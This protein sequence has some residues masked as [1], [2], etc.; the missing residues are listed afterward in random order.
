MDKPAGR[1]VLTVLLGLVATGCARQRMTTRQRYEKGL[2]ICLP[3]AGGFNF[4]AK[5]TRKGLEKGG[6]EGAV[7][8]YHWSSMNVAKDHLNLERN[9][10]K[11]AE[12]ARRIEAYQTEYPNRPVHLI[13]QSAGSG[14]AAWAVG[15][16]SPGHRVTGLVFVASSL[17][18]RYDLSAV[19]RKVDGALHNF[20]NPLDVVLGVGTPVAGAVDGS[21]EPAGGQVGFELPPAADDETKRLYAERLVQHAWKPGDIVQGNAGD[22]LGATRAGFVRYRIAPIIRLSYRLEEPR[23]DGGAPDPGR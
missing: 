20:Y 1:L 2:V 17:G 15:D 5:S 4:M 14:I 12:L 22:H 9:R 6:V 16:L 7:D 3:T 13:G 11:A 19:L 21:K 10:R 23:G 18:K 8:I